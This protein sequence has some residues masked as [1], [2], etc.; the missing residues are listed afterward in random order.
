MGY[1]AV[2]TLIA[3]GLVN[4]WFLVGSVSGLLETLYGQILLESWRFLLQCWRLPQRT[5]SG[6]S[7][8][9]RDARRFRR[10]GWV[11]R[12]VAVTMC[13]ASSSWA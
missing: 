2:A 7:A 9:D 4:S 13:S 5:G 11:A 12:T 1:V 8:D 3:S 10:A 6:S